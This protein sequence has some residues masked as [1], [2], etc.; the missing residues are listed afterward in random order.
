MSA[1]CKIWSPLV[2]CPLMRFYFPHLTNENLKALRGEMPLPM[3][4]DKVQGLKEATL[5]RNDA[6]L[7]LRGPHKNHQPQKVKCH[8]SVG[9][10][11][12]ESKAYCTIANTVLPPLTPG[13]R[14][15]HSSL[16]ANRSKRGTDVSPC[17]QS[18]KQP[19]SQQCHYNKNKNASMTWVTADDRAIS[20]LGNAQG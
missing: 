9:K 16:R 14:A 5:G 15:S 2:P 6:T 17:R 1:L 4:R 13:N 19:I 18:T 10:A 7:L 12:R 8:G 11:A 3:T 20:K